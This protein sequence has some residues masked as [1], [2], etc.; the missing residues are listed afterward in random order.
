ML[1]AGC[2]SGLLSLAAALMGA[3]YVDA[4]D[5]DMAA[6]SI[7]DRNAALNGVSNIITASTEPVASVS[8]RSAGKYHVVMANILAP[9]LGELAPHLCAALKPGGFLIL[10]GL[11]DT[12]IEMIEIAFRGVSLEDGHLSGK[13]G[14]QLGGRLSERLSTVRVVEDGVWRGLLLTLASA[15]PGAVSTDR[16]A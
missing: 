12:Q 10:A 5:I 3:A 1:D 2:G 9:V 6:P 11:I 14:G 13:L 16:R 7:V 4:V 15:Q 8:H